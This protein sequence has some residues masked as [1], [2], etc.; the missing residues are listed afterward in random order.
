MGSDMVIEKLI[1]IVV[2]EGIAILFLVF[3]YQ[4]GVKERMGF[5]A[6]YNDESAGRVRDKQ[7]LKR[8]ITRLCVLMAIASGLMPLLTF[9]A[10]AD[11]Q[12]MAH[13]IGGYGGF[14]TGVIAFVFLQVRDY[15]D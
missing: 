6:G 4:I 15:T 13:V 1:E 9:F 14:I 3:A 12:N 10:G 2:M 11:T 5:I 7:G 8:L